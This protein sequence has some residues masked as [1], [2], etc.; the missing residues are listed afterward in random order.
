MELVKTLISGGQTG[1]DML[2]LEVARQ[3]GIRTAGTATRNFEGIHPNAHSYGLTEFGQVNLST[4]EKGF[5]NSKIGVWTKPYQKLYNP[6]TYININRSDATVVY[7]DTQSPGSKLTISLLKEVGKP[8]IENPDCIAL[9]NWITTNGIQILNVAGNREVKLTAQ[10]LLH[11]RIALLG[12]LTSFSTR[13]TFLA[14]DKSI[15]T[16]TEYTRD[17]YTEV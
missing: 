9:H 2:G 11:Y 14:R 8:H 1:I 17:Q 4:D 7:G 15:F 3:L 6:R 10:Q 5:L 16:P 13:Y 12:G